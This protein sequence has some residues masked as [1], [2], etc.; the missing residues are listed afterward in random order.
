MMRRVVSVIAFGLSAAI[1]AQAPAQTAAPSTPPAIDPG[2]VQRQFQQPT[3][4]TERPDIETPEIAD[5]V[6]PESAAD[7]RLTLKAIVVD[8]ASVYSAA[9]FA[10]MSEPLLGHSVSLLEVFTLAD[11]ITAR[12][13]RDDYILSRAVV[14]A[15]KIDGAVMH[16]RVV[17]GYVHAVRVQGPHNGLLERY[18]A[19]ITASRPLRRAVLERYLLLMNALPGVTA[20]AV[21]EPAVGQTGGTDLTVIAAQKEADGFVSIDN[22][23]SRYLGPLEASAGVGI[24]DFFGW[25]ERT[26]FDYSTADP[27]LDGHG[28]ELDYVDLHE[29]VPLGADG[30]LLTL[31]GARSTATPGFTLEALDARTSGTSFSTQL[32]YPLVSSRAATWTVHAN[33]SYLDATAD[34]D[35]QPD[36]APSYVDRIRALRIGS[37]YDFADHLGG[38]NLLDAEF[39]QGLSVFDASDYRQQDISRP[40]AHGDYRKLTVDFSR[41]QELNAL[42]PHLDLLAAVAAQTSFGDALLSAEQFG[43]GGTTFGRG[44]EPS[45][46]V[47]DSGIAAKLELQYNERLESLA[48]QVQYYGFY[49][50]GEVR[51]A[52]G[53]AGVPRSASLASAGG[54]ARCGFPD[55]FSGNL[56]FA[57][58]LTKP[59]ETEVLSGSRDAKRPRAYFSVSKR[60]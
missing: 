56:E 9:D 1:A 41:R 27:K 57:K 38:H 28:R 14:P 50:V 2:R 5:N 60:F 19:A 23:G 45:E 40:G 6:P 8:G 33:F 51:D 4:E 32:S 42:A 58:P 29:E 20:R 24:N 30:L 15:Q 31:T 11:R 21:L 44:Y 25:G 43:L 16:I 10:A 7:T 52:L 13:R 59:V 36:S 54:G 55:G 49:D 26:A 37:G 46:I 39:S 12:Y 17:E 48:A 35:N 53:A 3:P 47:G 22:R 34:I 18:G